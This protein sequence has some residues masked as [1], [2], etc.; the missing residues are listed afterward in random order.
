[1]GHYGPTAQNY[2]L[3]QVKGTIY[4]V[5]PDGQAKADGRSLEKP[6]TLE[7]V[8]AR[9]KTGDAIVLRGGT[10]RTGGLVLNQGITLQPYQNERP[11]LKGTQIATEWTKQD[12]G[13]WRTSWDRLFPEKAPDWWR[14]HRHGQTIPPYLF[15]YD[16][17]FV[18]G[19]PLK[20]VGWEG[21][22]ETGTYSIDYE[23]GHVYIGVDP[24]QHTI[25]ITAHDSAL[26]RTMGE[27][28]GKRS[29]KIGPK[30]HGLT[31]TQYAYR[32][33]EI[34][35]SE[36]EGVTPEAEMGKDVVGTVL[37]NVTISHC[38][39]VAGYFR[40]DDLV[41]RNCLITDTG[42]EG[43]YII[44]S[45]DALLEGNIVT[46]TNVE[47][48]LG[49]FP[50]AIK[51]FN[52]THRVIVRD[53]LIIDNP[54]SSGVW[55]DV[56]NRE[57]QFYN[58]WVEGTDNGF[59]FEISQGAICAGNVFIDCGTGIYV[60][61]S[62]DVEIYQNTLLD[63]SI[64]IERTSRSALN[65]HFGWHPA[66]GPDVPER[67]GHIVKNNL[68]VGTAAFGNPLVQVLQE[69][70]LC[71]QLT[72]PQLQTL[73]HNAYVQQGHTQ[74]LVRL[75]PAEGDECTLDLPTLDRLQARS[76][77]QGSAAYV[78]YFG[79]LFQSARLHRL[80]PLA[81]F[82]GLN[83]ADPLPEQVAAWLPWTQDH[84]GVPGAFAPV[85]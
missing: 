21:E 74:P 81:E 57:G 8:I 76:L 41:I 23:T 56:G 46:R 43:L 67:D 5:A 65:D 25:E 64:K 2:E 39:R 29:D 28:H 49:V 11:I 82:P 47:E 59:F 77:G 68:M 10:Y 54:H 17:V 83:V 51:I 44:S 42:F 38:S 16:M 30:I 37:E 73:A 60:L 85:E 63:S 27:A 58:N 18:D 20:V 45:A 61:N 22:V 31:F 62:A 7:A 3:P 80:A 34:E 72:A 33:L 19:Q 66:T 71:G 52:Q 26:V 9:V 50:T 79:P 75:S 70:S 32:A 78:D 36:G 55:Y 24:A 12:N 69:A 40:G 48:F 15:N 35:G 14:R 6:S 1:M 53:N 4:Y 84:A 13:L